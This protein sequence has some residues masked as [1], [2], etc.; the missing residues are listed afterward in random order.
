MIKDVL[1]TQKREIEKR[2]AE[3]YVDRG[4]G[5]E[6]LKSPL[7][8]VIMGPRRAGK[9]FFAMHFLR[10]KGDFAYVNF[11]DERLVELKDYDDILSGM[12]AADEVALYRSM[13]T[14]FSRQLLMRKPA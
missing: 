10:Q 1:I 8:K 3:P 6:K 12:K 9:S 4:V 14:A 2:M 11:D 7:I 13:D 5:Q